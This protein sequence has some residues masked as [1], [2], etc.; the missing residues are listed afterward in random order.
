[1]AQWRRDAVRLLETR[2]DSRVLAGETGVSGLR[3]LDGSGRVPF[4]GLRVNSNVLSPR[5]LVPGL[6][7]DLAAGEHTLEAV[8]I[9]ASGLSDADLAARLERFTAD[10]GAPS[11]HGS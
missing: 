9:V 1:V 7:A 10:T 2:A 3:A 4:D 6:R 8:F 11:S 5:T